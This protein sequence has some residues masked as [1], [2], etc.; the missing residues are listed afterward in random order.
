MSTRLS[1]QLARADEP[2]HACRVVVEKLAE[3]PGLKP[4]V[5]LERGGRL[6]C[7]AARTY[8]QVLD[9]IPPGAGVI[10]RTY[11]SG[12]VTVVED[13][14]ACRDYLEIT[15]GVQVEICV[16][17]R[18]D[19][20]VI[21]VISVESLVE[22][23]SEVRAQVERCGVLLGERLAQLGGPLKETPAQRLVRRVAGFRALSDRT[24][25]EHT[26]LEIAREVAQMGSAALLAGPAEG[27]V[28]VTDAVGPLAPA[29][30]SS[31]QETLQA[32][33]GFVSAGVSCYTVGDHG[34]E[35]FLSLSTLRA[36]GAGSLVLM[37]IGQGAGARVLLVADHVRHDV[38][39][40]V[41]ELLELL[42]AQA[43]SALQ[44]VGLVEDLRVQ[45]ATDALT[46]LGHHRAFHARLARVGTPLTAVLV[47]DLDYFK[48]VND[49]YGHMA[50][51][52][53]L[54]EV[55][56]VLASEV[57][58]GDEV[59]RIGGDEFAAVVQIASEEQGYELARRLSH[60]VRRQ[61][62]VTV[63]IGVS[64]AEEAE[65]LTEALARADRAL[66]VAKAA[67]RDGARLIR[68]NVRSD[69]L[70]REPY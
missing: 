24:E 15:P 47:I 53:V 59:F 63:S 31:S 16:P 50:G 44:V 19:A 61:T 46:G 69:E 54:R 60:A 33:V 65:L 4:S 14:G 43:V 45:A 7:Q 13:V 36:A 12:E 18:A 58:H 57:R 26:I 8:R 23:H 39:T 29:L 3:T 17:I 55:A 2:R 22:L 30:A 62:N 41:V 68:A 49:R 42:C 21:G 9:G 20:R 11:R 56:A 25:V 70:A 51:D 48:T 27:P 66:Y 64:V 10:G 40:D 34:G 35:D 1:H 67:G 52:H 5:Y 37:P 28:K 6:R 32:T 38:A